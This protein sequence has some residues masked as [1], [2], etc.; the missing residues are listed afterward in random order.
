[1][2]QIEN[3]KGGVCIYQ[4]QICQEGFCSECHIH[5]NAMKTASTKQL[6]IATTAKKYK[7]DRVA[8]GR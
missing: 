8:A 5:Q 7:T 4:F 2:M 6:V 3:H 1:M